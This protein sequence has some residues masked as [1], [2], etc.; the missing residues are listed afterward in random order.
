MSDAPAGRTDTPTAA[1]VN[2]TSMFQE[3]TTAFRAIR[4]VNWFAAPGAVVVLSDIAY[5]V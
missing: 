3:D 4:R 2:L 1:S 5:G